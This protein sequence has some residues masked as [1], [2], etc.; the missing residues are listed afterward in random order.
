MRLIYEKVG[1]N[2]LA[3]KLVVGLSHDFQT[4]DPVIA[5]LTAAHLP[6]VAA[7]YHHIYWK[8]WRALSPDS[9][10]LLEYMPLAADIGMLEE[11][12]KGISGM[13]S[14]NLLAAIHELIRRSLLEVRGTPSGRRYGIHPL[15]R[16]FLLTD[17]IN[18]PP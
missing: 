16:S 15:T 8:A 6:D 10:R 9:R 11:Q 17:I 18:W 1:G 5:D 7:M 13:D 4:F 3:L 12:M 2:P 14:A